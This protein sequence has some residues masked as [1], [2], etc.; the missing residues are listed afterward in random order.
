[1]GNYLKFGDYSNEALGVFVTTPSNVPTPEERGESVTIP[2]RNGE[3]WISEGAYD[4][5]HIM[6]TFFIPP[7]ANFQTVRL[8]LT[9]EG[10]LELEKN[11][12]LYYKA[13]ISGGVSFAP[14][15]FGDGYQGSVDFE[16]YPF[17]YVKTYETQ[18]VTQSGLS[19]YNP[20]GVYSEPKIQIIG[21]GDKR[22]RVGNTTFELENIVSGMILDTEIQEAYSGETLLNGSMSG[23]FPVLASGFNEVTWQG[24][25]TISK[26]I[27]DPRWRTL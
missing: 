16:C 24:T 26:I 17:R 21:S 3:L 7:T 6:P 19:V 18:E 22:I 2:G 13:R 9:G 10:Q 25:G 1:M 27:F 23:A 12:T 11:A 4:P 8:W 5:I 20:Y 15:T 14:Y